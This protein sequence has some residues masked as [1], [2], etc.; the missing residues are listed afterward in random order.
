[1]VN[2]LE[3]TGT[4]VLVNGAIHLQCDTNAWNEIEAENDRL[5]FQVQIL[6]RSMLIFAF[7]IVIVALFYDAAP[8]M[9]VAAIPVVIFFNTANKIEELDK[10]IMSQNCRLLFH[11]QVKNIYIFSQNQSDKNVVAATETAKYWINNS[12]NRTRLV[13]F[14]A[15]YQDYKY[16]RYASDIRG[17]YTEEVIERDK[18]SYPTSESFDAYKSFC[19]DL[20][21]STTEARARS[22][23]SLNNQFF[24]IDQYLK[25][26]R[27]G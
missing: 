21:I 4:D 1:M 19:S 14:W 25:Q 3:Y 24:Y 6:P 20:M 13:L 23:S 18:L 8:L 5:R 16:Q 27:N 11:N 26:N 7:G 9:F 12:G 15:V 2:T 22:F 10:V 17:T